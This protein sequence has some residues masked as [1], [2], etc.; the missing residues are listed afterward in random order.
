MVGNIETYL[1]FPPDKSTDKAILILT[2]VIGHKYINVQLIADQFAANGYFVAMPDLFNGDPVLLNR[3]AGFDVMA[4]LKSG[5][6]TKEVDPIVETVIKELRGKYGVNKLGAV[7]YCFGAK[8]VVR[9][10]KAGGQI[11]AGF[12]AHPSFVEDAEFK[13]IEGPLSIAAAETDQIFP[14]EKRRQSEDILF[15]L[16]IPWQINVYSDVQHG[17]AVRADL[18]NPRVKWAKEQAFFQAVQWFDEY[19]KK[20]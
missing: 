18:T 4:W 8:Y 10:L 1:A 9:Y 3:P 19:V 6:E 5:H 17:F 16:D 12:V 2:D 15:K 7:G 14:A 20:A 13:A 11:D